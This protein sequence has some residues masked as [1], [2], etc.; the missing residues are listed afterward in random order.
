MDKKKQ[1]FIDKVDFEKLKEKAKFIDRV[2][3]GFRYY[4]GP[5]FEKLK[6]KDRYYIDIFMT[7]IEHLEIS[8]KKIQEQLNIIHKQANE[9]LST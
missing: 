8:M 9:I 1:K 2:D 5:N 6:E 7:Y 3:E 4:D